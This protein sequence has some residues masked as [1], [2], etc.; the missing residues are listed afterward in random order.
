MKKILLSIFMIMEA[1]AAIGCMDKSYHMQ[2]SGDIK[3]FHYVSC[4]CPCKYTKAY[5][6][7]CTR[8]NHYG[9]SDRG[10][11]N[12]LQAYESVLR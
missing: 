7:K 4:S 8:C 3:E 10:A 6:G 9:R 2:K 1:S 12:A 11:L 5:R